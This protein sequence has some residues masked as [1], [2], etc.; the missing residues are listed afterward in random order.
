VR[1]EKVIRI[2]PGALLLLVATAAVGCG[3]EPQSSTTASTSTTSSS[4]GGQGGQGG[5]GGGAGGEGGAGGQGGGTADNGHP[6]TETVSAGEVTASSKYKMV[7]TL[8]QPTQNQGKTTSS[9]YRLQ[10]GLVGANGSVQ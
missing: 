3:D 1:I 2:A 6:A 8:G 10:G 7:F 9:Q 4:S 5:E